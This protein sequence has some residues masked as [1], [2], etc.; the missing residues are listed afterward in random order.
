MFSVS[1]IA[2]FTIYLIGTEKMAA[3]ITINRHVLADALGGMTLFSDALHQKNVAIEGDE[4]L[5]LKLLIH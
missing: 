5:V 4:S 1:V 3:T 2:L